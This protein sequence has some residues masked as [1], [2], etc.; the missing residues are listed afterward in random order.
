MSKLWIVGLLLLS[1]PVHAA[2]LV[3]PSDFMDNIKTK[4]GAKGDGVTDDTIAIQAALN[5]NRS[6][7]NGDYYGLPKALYFPAGTYLVSK[8]IG[9]NGCCVTIQGQGMGSTMIKLKDSATG[10]QNVAQPKPVIT[11]PAGNQSFLQ[12]FYDLTINTG[13]GNTGAMGVSYIASNVGTI[14]NISIISEDGKGKAGLD[15]SRQWPGP[16]L[17]KN[18]TVQGFNYGIWV[19]NSEYG[20]TFE[21]ITLKNQRVAGIYN[22]GNTLAV[23]NLTSINT[24]PAIKTNQSSESVILIGANLKSGLSTVSAIDSSGLLYARQVKTQGYQSAIRQQGSVVPGL[25]VSE[26]ISGSTYSL[27]PSAAGSL[28]LPV[29]ETPTFVDTDLANWG[30]FNAAYYGDTGSLQALLNS[31]KSTIYFSHSNYFSYL[32]AVMTVPAT[33]KRI[34]GFGSDVN[35]GGI[36]FVVN[37]N[38]TT[39][40]IIEQFN[41]GI[42][43]EQSSART[44]VLKDGGYAYNDSPQA[45]KLFLSNVGISPL[46]INYP[47][48]VWAR[49]LNAE[50]SFPKVNNKGGTLWMLGLKTEG[51]DTVVTTTAGG[52][53]EMLGTLIY[54]AKEFSASELLTPAFVNIDSSQS[55]IY[56]ISSYSPNGN[57]DIQVQETRNGITKNLNT[58]DVPGYPFRMP[59]FVGKP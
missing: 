18:V 47:H 29:E 5:D 52:K 38:S 58:L 46:N 14:E 21:N 56:S 28:K 55:L 10:F 9:W 25:S 2:P 34:V 6:D 48:A 53:T 41:Y 20:P 13:Q 54:P 50:G 4:Y 11:M 32:Q 30:H 3:F 15:M 57:Y 45:G 44:V 42:K 1:L 24:V 35:G 37:E 27:F 22:D 19:A 8:T 59:L 7:P 39:P 26:Y 17:I 12:N 16:C 43:V 36:K 51:S 23:R 31:G 49:Q 40:L 33:V